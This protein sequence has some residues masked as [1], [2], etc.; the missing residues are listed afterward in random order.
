MSF[1]VKVRRHALAELLIISGNVSGQDAVVI[2][3]KVEFLS[4]ADNRPV[5][6]DLSSVEF[7]DSHG[8]GVLVYIWKRL[9]AEGRELVFVNPAEFVREIL[10]ST[11]LEK[12]IRIVESVEE[13]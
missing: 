5:A 4:S 8:L 3:D 12:L 2:K 6:I 13:L 11:N 10:S 1:K 7:I 9:E